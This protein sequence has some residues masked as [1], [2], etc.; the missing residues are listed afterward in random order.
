M[1]R[2]LSSALKRKD[3]PLLIERGYAAAAKKKAGRML[4]HRPGLI[5]R[6][7]TIVRSIPSVPSRR[8]R[9]LSWTP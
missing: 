7:Q 2:Q 3:E 5:F 9:R 4:S 6:N 8:G 1:P